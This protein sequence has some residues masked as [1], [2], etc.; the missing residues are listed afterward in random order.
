MFCT[1]KLRKPF[2]KARCCGSNPSKG[3]NLI[4]TLMKKI[5]YAV[6][7]F[8]GFILIVSE[9]TTFTPNYLGVAI[10]VYSAYKLDLLTVLK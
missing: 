10:F 6:A 8:V 2:E 4:L 7:L 1:V 9:S 5:I 3:A